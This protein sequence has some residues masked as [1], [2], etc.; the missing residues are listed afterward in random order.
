MSV[1][2]YTDGASSP[3]GMG[4]FSALMFVEGV[5]IDGRYGGRRETTNNQMELQG[6]IE[7]MKLLPLIEMSR[8]KDCGVVDKAHFEGGQE[9]LAPPGHKTGGV[10][11]PDCDYKGPIQRPVY[12]EA[13]IVSD[14]QYC[15]NGATHWVHGWKGNGWE[16]KDKKPVKNKELWEEV[17]RLARVTGARFE[18]VKGHGTDHGNIVADQWAVAG[19]EK[20]YQPAQGPFFVA[21]IPGLET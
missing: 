12:P 11:G 15:V 18:W 6:L 17:D 8:C 14:S 13:V 2:V 4:G 20:M 5:L 10:L 21:T 1:R 7:G 9:Y 16:T 3:N 19:K